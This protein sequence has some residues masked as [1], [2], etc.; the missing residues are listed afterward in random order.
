MKSEEFPPIQSTAGDGS[1]NSGIRRPRIQ[2]PKIAEIVAANLRAQ[3]IRG[4]LREGDALPPEA[5]LIMHFGVSRPTLREA[6]RILEMES[7]ITIRR[8]SRGGAEIHR[9]SLAV[10]AQYTGHL[11]QAMGATLKDVHVART[12]IEPA[13]ARIAAETATPES[14]DRLRR[15]LENERATITDPDRFAHAAVAFHEEVIRC[16]NNTTLSV[17]W[18]MLSHIVDAHHSAVV[19]DVRSSSGR[20]HLENRQGFR[21]HSKFLELLQRNDPGAVE[22]F[23]RKH[24]EDAGAFMFK[25]LGNEALLDVLG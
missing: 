5:D 10:S 2:V 19:A 25:R 12:I 13:A 16:A 4:D 7:L 20:H 22:D 3:I 1:S 23:W 15:A 18:G 24:L 11:L 6:F 17:L 8:G 9:P 21:S 14:L